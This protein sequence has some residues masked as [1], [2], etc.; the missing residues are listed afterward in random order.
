[1]PFVNFPPYRRFDGAKK[2]NALKPH[3]NL[4]TKSWGRSPDSRALLVIP[5]EFCKH[6]MKRK[7][8]V[9]TENVDY[10]GGEPQLS[11]PQIDA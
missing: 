11:C 3:W 8:R 10:N 2:P 5:D 7:V 9:Y 4:R 6:V 1:M